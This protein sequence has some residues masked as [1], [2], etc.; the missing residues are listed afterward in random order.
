MPELKWYRVFKSPQE[1]EERIPL[2]HLQLVR[3]GERRIC[4]AHTDRGF[5]AVSDV[6]PHLSESLS[7]G[8]TNYLNEVICPWHGYRFNL[9]HGQE[10]QNRTKPLL[11][12]KIEL[13]DDGLFLGV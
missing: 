7:K 2:G 1:A 8:S 10:C 12:Y 3:I 11:I 4:I 9:E 6:C 5:H 13:R